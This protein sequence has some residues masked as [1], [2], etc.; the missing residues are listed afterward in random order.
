MFGFIADILTSI[1]SILFPIFA[2]YKALRTSDPAVLTPWLMYWTTLSLFLLVESQLYFILYWVPF[3]SWIRLGIH[4]Y[5]VLPGKQGSVY[6]YQT[7]IHPFL[8]EHERQIDQMI[9]NA[10]EKARAAGM[11][12][13]KKGVEYVRVNVLGQAPSRPSPPPSRNVSY[14]TYLFNRFAMPSAREGLAAAGTSDLFGLLGR[15]LQQST[16]PNKTPQEQARELA[17]SGTLIPPS[18]SE[19]ERES[20]VNTQRERLRTL[21][22]AFDTEAF[23][24][25][26]AATSGA[27]IRSSTP[28]QP[29]SR[30]SY[31]A[32]RA[33]DSM[34][35]PP[36]MHQSRSESEFED[37]GYETMP[38]PEQY[39][40]YSEHEREDERPRSS[41]SR[42]PGPQS[43]GGWSNWIWGS[44]GEK[45]SALDVPK[46]EL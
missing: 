30:K 10:H 25:H 26:D 36:Y 40:A 7:Y 44:Y 41:A 37:L 46:K 12:V 3:Y 19:A 15:A 42:K 11:D 23:N 8:E 39:R 14:S 13:V 17:E 20:F 45:D 31:P 33:R 6:I 4:L 27:Q 22:Q 9:G 28:R 34:G 21:L 43:G 18:L 32:A 35:P 16:Y 2:S 38:D 29:S 5:L 1:T 24:L